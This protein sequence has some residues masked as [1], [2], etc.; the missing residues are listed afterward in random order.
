MTT[1]RKPNLLDVCAALATLC[2][3]LVEFWV[4]AC[5]GFVKRQRMPEHLNGCIRFCK[6]ERSGKDGIP[7]N[8][9]RDVHGTPE[10]KYTRR[11]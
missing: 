3:E 8:Q 2:I 4:Q 6:W 10:V 7:V 9:M 5:P 1:T 11:R